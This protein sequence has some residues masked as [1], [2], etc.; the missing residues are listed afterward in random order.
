MCIRLFKGCN[1]CTDT[2]SSAT[3]TVSAQPSQQLPAAVND[4]DLSAHVCILVCAVNKI[5]QSN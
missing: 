4:V 2:E 5:V 3:V 1:F